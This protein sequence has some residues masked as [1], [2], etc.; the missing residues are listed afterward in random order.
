[1]FTQ[2]LKQY[3]NGILETI[4]KETPLIDGKRLVDTALYSR[5]YIQGDTDY[6]MLNEE[7]IAYEL[8]IKSAKTIIEQRVEEYGS[9]GSQ[10]DEIFH[11]MDAWKERIQSVKD[12]YPKE[13]E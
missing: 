9:I 12:K 7:K 3:K 10:L 13:D 8:S 2:K 6:W 5:V 4:S 11:N 1:M